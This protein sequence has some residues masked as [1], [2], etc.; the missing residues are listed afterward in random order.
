MHTNLKNSKYLAR[1]FTRQVFLQINTKEHFIPQ[2]DQAQ[3]I[4]KYAPYGAGVLL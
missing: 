4:E 2:H 1:R 3:L